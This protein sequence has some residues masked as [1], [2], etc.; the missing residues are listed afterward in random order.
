M[1]PSATRPTSA[2]DGFSVEDGIPPSILNVPTD[3]AP[4]G[5][6]RMLHGRGPT[7]VKGQPR[8]AQMGP[9]PSRTGRVNGAVMRW[10]VP[11]PR[12]RGGAGL[13]GRSRTPGPP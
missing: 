2:E 12:A 3:Y 4:N 7:G 10:H 11:A 1:P 6:W 13:P 8:A 5:T 9:E